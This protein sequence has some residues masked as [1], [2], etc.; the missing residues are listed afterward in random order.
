MET[1]EGKRLMDQRSILSE[2]AFGNLKENWGY[3]KLRRRGESGVKTEM[4]LMA[5]GANLR[6][7]HRRKVEKMKQADEMIAKYLH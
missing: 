5:I 4:H 1:D 2:G 3:T 7:Y 6:K